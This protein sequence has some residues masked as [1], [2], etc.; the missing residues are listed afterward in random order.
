M[1][2]PGDDDEKKIEQAEFKSNSDLSDTETQPVE[3]GE[4]S[5]PQF[6]DEL[7][8]EFEH[9]N[10]GLQY[11]Q[12]TLPVD[13]A[14]PFGDAFETQMVNFGD[15]TQVVDITCETQ[16]VDLGGE[17][18]VFDGLDTQ[19]QIDSDAGGSDKTE[20]LSY[21]QELSDDDPA[22]KGIDCLD[23]LE[24]TLDTE[25]SKQ[26]DG[27]SKAQSDA[28][29][30][31]GHCSGSIAR[32]FT[33]VRAASMRASGLAARNMAI[34][35]IDSS[36]CPKNCNDSLDV[37]PAEKDKSH[38][39]RD[40]LKLTDE[41]NQ[42]HSMEDYDPRIK[43]LGNENTRKLG[44]SAVRKLFMDEVV[45]EIKQAD[46]GWNSSDGTGG[47]PQL[48]S[49][50][51]LA[52]LSYVDSQEPGDLSQAN[53]LDV[54]DKFLELNVAGS[55]Q[56]VTFSKSNRRKSRSVS[57]GKGIQSLAK[58]A[59][60]RSLHGGKGIFNWD[61]DLEDEGGGEFFQKKKELFFENRS[62]RQRS[63]PHSTK[64][65]C[66]T[67]KS[68][69]T[70]PLDTDE[71]KIVDNTRNLKDAF[72]SDS[73]LLSKNSRANESSKP[74]KASFKR[75][76]LPVMDEEM[77]DASVERVVDAVAHKDLPDK[78]DVGFDTQMA[79][80]AMEALQFA[81]SVKENDC[82]NGDEG[83]TSV[84]KSAR[85][86]DRSSFN[87]SITLK[88]TCSSDAELITRQ[89]KK[90][91]RTGVKLSRESN[92]SSVKQSKN[93]K[94]SKRA[95][96]NLK[97]LITN[98]TENLSTVSKVV[99]PRQ[100]DRVPVGSDVDNINQT[101]ATASAGRKSLKRHPLIEEL[102]SLTPIAH[103]TRTS[104]KASQSKAENKLDSSRLG[105]GVG[106][107][108][109]NNAM[110]IGQ[111]NQDRC[112]NVKT[113]VLEYPKGRRTRSKLPLASQEASAQNI[114][115][116]KRSKRDVTSSSMNPVEN[117]D[118]RTSV[119]GGKIILAD[120]TDAGGSLHGNLSN[121]QENV[122][123]SIISNHSGI[124][125]DM[126]NSRS[127]EG[128]I[129][130]GS[131]DASPKD[132]RKP[133]AST[134]TT[135]V[136][137]TTPISAASPI[138][139]GDEY[140]KQSCRKNLLGL[141]LMKELNSRTN[142][143]SPL[144]TGGV[145]DLRRR[146]DM[147]TVRAMFSRHLDADTVKQQKKILARFGA[148]IASSMSEATHFITDEFVR[149]RNMLEA[150]A[151]GKPVVTHLW[152]E[153]CGQ[154][155]CFIDERNYI[156]RDARKEKEFGFSMPVSLSRACQHPLLQG[157]RVLITPNTKPG[158]EILG[159]LVKAVHGL[160]VER[161]GRSAWKDERLPDDIL[162]LSCEEDYE[163][164]VPF[165]EKGAAVYSSELLLNGIVIQRLE[166]E[167]HRLFVDN[168][169]R[170]RSTIWL[171]KN[172]SNQYLPVTKSK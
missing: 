38:S 112:S 53:A 23:D 172:S 78:M 139:M 58:K 110:K 36:S 25:L 54:V 119:S 121:I 96:A 80:D 133:E 166:Y 100:E 50:H 46:D 160:A 111:S 9:E 33:S 85:T 4:F 65:L 74:R 35:R 67:S 149:T 55:D 159:S 84:T 73:R 131:E 75:N 167:R 81:V 3:N 64:P 153:S 28:L 93:L 82:M 141:S 45:S 16:V 114:T 113:F 146:R 145:K 94:R 142:T 37:Q 2:Q 161:L 10:D 95:K 171:K 19:V 129:M 90:A 48:A 43:E 41:F 143:T 132:R 30:N 152:L 148:L 14:F 68:S 69:L 49:E 155:N 168:V 26:S 89:S 61:D 7:A 170:T 138:C 88:R 103:R 169:K 21:T 39:S 63:I 22:T 118:E 29:S 163:I 98:G 12:D 27:A 52:G 102:G 44:S 128:E 151:F 42:K 117:Q 106:K 24:I 104:A 77:S 156:L 1:G 122:V 32:T 11:I 62:L 70:I 108:R 66:L 51:D 130:N 18:Q 135:P 17:T 57:S 87:E 76:L 60:V 99:E 71:K 6:H 116:F 72:L 91:R 164:C 107:L 137:F 15:E 86:D 56:D 8:G 120:R 162:I 31:E 154:A 150:I 123:K 126:D 79:A 109:H 5:P 136:S 158:K 134:S 13:D 115:R 105:N 147:T 124:K 127:A 97:D 140:H 92:S 157:L 101:L 34:K 40:S 59:A 165:L 20:V 83:I 125:I 144:F 47:V